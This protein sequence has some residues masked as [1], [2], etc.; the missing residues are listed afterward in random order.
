MLRIGGIKGDERTI[1]RVGPQALRTAPLVLRDDGVRGGEDVLRR[2]VVLF[3][4]DRARTREVALELFDVA[5]R[6]TA[7]GV[8]RLVGVADDGELGGRD[9]VLAVPDEETD[10][11]VLRVVRVLILIDEDVAETPVIV[12]GEEAVA[13]EELHGPHDEVVEIEGVRF[14][15]PF[16]VFEVGVGDDLRD[17]VLRR[18][19]GVLLRRD[20]LVLEV[21]DP[22]GD[23]FGREALDIDIGGFEDD[24]DE[25]LGVL[26]V[27][28]REGRAQ[29]RGLVLGA[30]DP[31]A[32][33]VEGRDPH[34]RGGAPD[35]GADPFAHLCG[36]LVREG[37][38]KDLPGARPARRERVG[39]AVGEDA[40][41]PGS[42]SRHDEQRPALVEDRLR[43][44]LVESA[45]ELIGLG[46]EGAA[47]AGMKG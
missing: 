40:G 8:D 26:R 3:E 11:H 38:G 17:R 13:G 45:Q 25:A 27:I 14:A 47:A 29:A 18:G 43:L 20:E 21:G 44:L 41:L 9:P 2:A 36:G 37:D 10:E 5:D 4:E 1:A 32:R 6:R 15:H 7:E 22:G 46:A 34:P 16:L 31:H 23:E 28:D 42:G 19:V 24:L 33:R 39:D 30:E 12:L 35:E